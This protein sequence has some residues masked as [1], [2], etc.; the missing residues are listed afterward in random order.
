MF[1]K[2]TVL[3]ILLTGFGAQAA[4]QG[5]QEILFFSCGEPLK[6]ST[7]TVFSD[8]RVIKV[9]VVDN[10]EQGR[11][12]RTLTD[13]E[14]NTLRADIQ[15]VGERGVDKSAS[16]QRLSG[17]VVSC[18]IQGAVEIANG[19]SGTVVGSTN[20]KSRLIKIIDQDK[21]ELKWKSSESTQNILNFI[22]G[23]HP[24]LQLPKVK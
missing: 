15:E 1:A 17:G 11:I 20:N 2:V 12:E 3:A 4:E 14:L 5:A 22:K 21:S 6:M 19:V 13:A 7:L 16:S 18:A 9:D 23:F 8:A 10:K 24:L